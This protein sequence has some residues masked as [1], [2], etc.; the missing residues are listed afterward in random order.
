[1]TDYNGCSLSTLSK[2]VASIN[3]ETPAAQQMMLWYKTSEM[4]P[5][6]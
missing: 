1:M 6:R 4:N 3:P 2:S 5:D